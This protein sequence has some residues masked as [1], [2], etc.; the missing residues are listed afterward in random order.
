MNTVRFTVIIFAFTAAVCGCAT[1]AP[2]EYTDTFNVSS[3]H[4]REVRSGPW[5]TIEKTRF[6]VFADHDE[7][8]IHVRGRGSNDADMK[9]NFDFR[10]IEPSEEW[11]PGAEGRIRVHSGFFKRYTAIRTLLFD[12]IDQ[13]PDYAIRLGGF[14]LGGTWTQFFLLDVILHWP[15]KDILGIF[16]APANP[17]RRLPKQYQRELKKRTVFVSNAWDPITWMRAVGFKRYGYNITIG[18]WWRILPP[19]HDPPQMIRSL[20]ERFPPAQREE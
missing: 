10:I 18:R 14:S 11:F 17:W 8:I 16:Y 4:F 13:Y 7:K 9:D 12:T 20:D 15:D 2:F 1:T 19:Q 5:E 3:A 6:R